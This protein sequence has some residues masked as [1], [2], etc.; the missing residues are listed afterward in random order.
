MNVALP[1]HTQVCEGMNMRIQTLNHSTY[2]HL[3]HIVWSTK[4]RRNYLKPKVVQVELVNSLFNT[5]KQ[6]PEIY[7]TTVKTDLDHVHLQIEIAPSISVAAVV[8]RLKANASRHLK[9]RFPFIRRM[10]FDG[11]IWSVGYFSS[12]NG[13]NDETV[14]RYIERQGRR[15]YPQDTQS[16]F[17]FS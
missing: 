17:G 4:Y 8:Q 3:Y 5:A 13:L 9:N 2:Q 7:I 11:G 6:H 10:Y 16:K 12:T 14:R 15:D 1:E